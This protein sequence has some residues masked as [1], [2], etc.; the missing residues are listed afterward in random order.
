MFPEEKHI[1]LP[2]GP[3]ITELAPITAEDGDSSSSSIS[4]RIRGCLQVLGAFF[5]LF[6]VWYVNHSGIDIPI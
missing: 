2:E 6:N 5:I 4:S 1:T 3:D